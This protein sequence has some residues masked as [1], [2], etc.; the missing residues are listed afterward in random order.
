MVADLDLI[1]HGRIDDTSAV[2]PSVRLR[3]TRTRSGLSLLSLGVSC[4]S[5]LV[6]ESIDSALARF[7]H[8]FH[9]KPWAFRRLCR[10]W[11]NSGGG[12]M[13]SRSPLQSGRWGL[14]KRGPI[15]PGEAPQL[16]ETETMGN[17]G[18]VS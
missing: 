3:P 1:E 11:E 6:A 18:D 13:H 9:A 17:F 8:Q 2:F 16:R 12:D 10:N 14:A 5:P 4:I 7:P 15:C